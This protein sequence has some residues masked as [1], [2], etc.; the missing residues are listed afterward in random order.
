MTALGH[1][2]PLFRPSAFSHIEIM[3][4]VWPQSDTAMWSDILEEEV[5]SGDIHRAAAE[6][7]TAY[8]DRLR[9]TLSSIAEDVHVSIVDADA[10]SAVKA[11]IVEFRADIVFFI[12]GSV[13]A[14]SQIAANLQ[15]VLRESPVP[16]SVL[17]APARAGA[18]PAAN[19][20][21]ASKPASALS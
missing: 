7:S 14:D 6:I 9:T 16:V 3:M 20:T 13:D 2:L 19:V 21:D 8:A 4:L 1:V 15:D 11:A 10:V 18:A 5:T 17:H 12:I